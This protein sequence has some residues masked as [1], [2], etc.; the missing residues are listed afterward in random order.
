MVEQVIIGLKERE[1]QL[2]DQVSRIHRVKFKSL[3]EQQQKIR[4]R[5]IFLLKKIS[6]IRKTFFTNFASSSFLKNNFLMAG[7]Y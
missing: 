1:S 6:K 5:Q 3:E 2:L 7:N 4:K